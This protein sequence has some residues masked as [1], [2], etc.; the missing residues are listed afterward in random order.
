MCIRDRSCG[1][2]RGP[3]RSGLARAFVRAALLPGPLWRAPGVLRLLVI[4][5]SDQCVE[6]WRGPSA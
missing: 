3:L 1:G 2:G 5:A 4:P 6:A